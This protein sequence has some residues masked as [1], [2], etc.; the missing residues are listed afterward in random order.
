MQRKGEMIN[1]KS[2]TAFKRIKS[3]S[4][5]RLWFSLSANPV[6]VVFSVMFL[7]AFKHMNTNKNKDNNANHE[8]SN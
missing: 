1:D 7:Q 6:V 4:F 2:I 8:T 5:G 3:F